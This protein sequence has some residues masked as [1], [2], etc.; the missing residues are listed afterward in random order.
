[1]CAFREG[2]AHVSTDGRI[3][4]LTSPDGDTWKSAAVLTLDG[5]D[6]RDAGLSIT[7]DNRL[8]LNG[9]AAPRKT[10][11]DNAPTGTFVAFSDDG[12]TWTKPEIVV[13]PGRWLWRVD[14]ARRQGVRHCV[15][16]RPAAEGRRSLHAASRQRRRL[17]FTSR[18]CRN[19]SARALR[20]RPRCD[21][22]RTARCIA[23]SAATATEATASADGTP[24]GHRLF[25]QPAGRRTPTGSGT[26]LGDP[27][28]RA[29]FHSACRP[30]NGS[31]P[32][33][34][35]TT[36]SPKTKLAG[37]TSKRPTIEPILE[38]PS[39]GDTSYPGLVW[40]DDTLWVSYY[41]SHEG[42]TNIYLAKV[43]D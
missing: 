21:L 23:C 26:I 20:P 24:N 14:L 16:Q 28:R 38:L 40:H 8:M 32:A 11:K 3:R 10:D 12:K 30:E 37:S 17:K 9:G 41:S 39:G 36:K 18:W 7:P 13:E 27:R 15:C 22:R 42:K 43:D 19:Y 29:E 34:S 2:R 5:Y 33:D 25:R 1:M 35:F 6:L 31:P 4:I